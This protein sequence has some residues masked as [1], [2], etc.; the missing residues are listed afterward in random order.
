MPVK[1]A[2][3]CIASQAEALPGARLHFRIDLI[4]EAWPWHL[5][6]QFKGAN[7]LVSLVRLGKKLWCF[8]CTLQRAGLHCEMSIS[9]LD[10]RQISGHVLYE[11]W[12]VLPASLLRPMWH[13]EHV[14]LIM[15]SWRNLTHPSDDEWLWTWL[16][17]EGNLEGFLGEI[18]VI[19]Q[20]DFWFQLPLSL[21][22]EYFGP[23]S[24]FTQVKWTVIK[25]LGDLVLRFCWLCCCQVIGAILHR[26]HKSKSHFRDIYLCATAVTSA[27]GVVADLGLTFPPEA[28]RQSWLEE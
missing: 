6:K 12:A 16:L 15:C 2:V 22:I 3:I 17:S 5:H 14:H 11:V 1:W 26:Q 8:A 24:L 10:A 7:F 13:H 4:G 19:S 9:A 27:G 21:N 20:E 28:D 18:S 25:Y 23:V